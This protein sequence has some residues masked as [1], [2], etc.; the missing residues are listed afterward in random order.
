MA[1]NNSS[2]F[3]KNVFG[4]IKSAGKETAKSLIPNLSSAIS[5]NKT[6]IQTAYTDTRTKFTEIDIKN[7]YLFKSGKNLIKNAMSDLKTGNLNNTQ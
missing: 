2:G 6:V 1:K 3:L 7:N 4:S 5:T